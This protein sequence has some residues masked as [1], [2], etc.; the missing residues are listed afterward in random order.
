MAQAAVP[1]IQGEL[2]LWSMIIYD[3][4][5]ITGFD[6]D[7]VLF[8]LQKVKFPADK[9]KS[10]VNGL[11]LASAV[12]IIKADESDVVGK[13]QAL[14]SRW[15]KSMTQPNQWITLVEAIVMC[16]E[17]AVARDLAAAVGVDYPPHSGTAALLR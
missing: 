5:V 9:W 14:I 2:M 10:L 12:P 1:T 17:P 3:L 16:D 15:V 4:F 13:L 6:L 8:E 11:R 7:N